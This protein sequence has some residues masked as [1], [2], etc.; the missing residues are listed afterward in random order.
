MLSDKMM[1][2]DRMTKGCPSCSSGF[3]LRHSFVIRHSSF[4]FTRAFFVAL[5]AF[6]TIFFVL[7]R[8]RFF[9]RHQ[10]DE[11][12]GGFFRENAAE[13]RECVCGNARVGSGG[14]R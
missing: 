14:N 12:S 13:G 9:A 5:A 4:R 2:N 11:I 8:S 3:E 6:P 1:T 10:P 7:S